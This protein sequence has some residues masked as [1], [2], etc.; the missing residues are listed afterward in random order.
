MRHLRQY[1]KEFWIPFKQITINIDQKP[2]DPKLSTPI[3][4]YMV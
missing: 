4:N 2:K 3:V 1:K